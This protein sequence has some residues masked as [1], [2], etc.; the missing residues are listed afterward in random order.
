[1]TNYKA[2]IL[3][4]DGTLIGH[5]YTISPRVKNAIFSVKD[6]VPVSLCT[7]R[8]FDRIHKYVNELELTSMQMCDDGGEIYDPLN[9]KPV[10]Q[11]IIDLKTAKEIILE[12]K[13]NKWHYVVS[14]NSEYYV[15][16]PYMSEE[17]L[18]KYKFAVEKEMPNLN[19][20]KNPKFTKIT[21]TG[22]TSERQKKVE[23]VL[24]PFSEKVHFIA[25]AYGLKRVTPFYAV[26]ITEKSATKLTV[27][28]EY[29]RL[30]NI[31][32]SQTIVIGDGYNDF[33][34]LMAGGLKVAMGNAPDD[35]KKIADYVAPSVEQDGVAEVIEKFLSPV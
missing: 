4:V 30:N 25:A 23:E 21:I 15:D 11:K 33:P 12:I 19:N 34:L 28:E 29:A 22:V 2:L 5:E 9:H 27:L 1:M 18:R 16:K 14:Y 31:D 6:K 17:I 8:C 32:L 3:D 13:K 26:D 20:V 10:Y 35:L 24:Q 7:G